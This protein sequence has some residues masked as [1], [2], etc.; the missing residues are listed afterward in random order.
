MKIPLKKNNAGMTLVEL[1]V[2]MTIF[3]M[4]ISSVFL[5]VQYMSMARMNTAHR[6]ELTQQLY[7]FQEQ[8]FTLIKDGGTIDFEEYW[9]RKV[10]GTETKNGHYK[11]PTGFGNYGKGGSVGEDNF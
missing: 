1:M 10:F 2:A 11:T 8:L 5:T 9:N 6:M 7:L 4:I 3:A